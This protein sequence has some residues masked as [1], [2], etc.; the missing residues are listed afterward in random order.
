MINLRAAISNP[1]SKERF[2]NL[3]CLHG[4]IS[5]N[6]AWELEHTFY[7]GLILDIDFTFNTKCDHAG[8]NIVLG[9]LGYGIHFSVYDT[10]HWDYENNCW[11]TY[12]H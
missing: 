1:W 5:K 4:R 6:K 10:R 9:I 7:D 11:K 8:L 3:G 2:K 12:E